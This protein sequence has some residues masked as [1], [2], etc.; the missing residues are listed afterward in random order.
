V[1][2]LK[3]TV[4]SSNNPM[5]SWIPVAAVALSIASNILF[6]V[7]TKSVLRTRTCKHTQSEH[8]HIREACK[9][10]AVASLFELSPQIYTYIKYAARLCNPLDSLFA[11]TRVRVLLR[12]ISSL[13]LPSKCADGRPDLHV[14][15]RVG[16]NGLVCEGL[17]S[18][19]R[20]A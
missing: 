20:T 18:L 16:V 6:I 8:A 1:T 7:C 12:P 4:S 15:N 2:H 5:P 13:Q 14:Y 11:R 9:A 17:P 10:L 19:A 3:R